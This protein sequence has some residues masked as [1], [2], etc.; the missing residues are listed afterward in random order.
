MVFKLNVLLTPPALVF[1]L[2]KIK[3]KHEN[4]K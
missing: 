1:K 3:L 4:E 2:P